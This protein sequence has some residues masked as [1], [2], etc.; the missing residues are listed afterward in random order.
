M[1][2]FSC[3]IPVAC[4][5]FPVSTVPYLRMKRLYCPWVGYL[6]ILSSK[7]LVEHICGLILSGAGHFYIVKSVY[8]LGRV[9]QAAVLSNL[10][11][12]DS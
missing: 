10:M 11:D 9:W 6:L 1:T 7:C 8:L 3:H 5:S 2:N 12:K 4:P